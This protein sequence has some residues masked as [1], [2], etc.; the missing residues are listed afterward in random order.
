[1]GLMI[2]K[3]ADRVKTFCDDREFIFQKYGKG[4][5]GLASSGLFI[6]SQGFSR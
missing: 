2:L 4:R 6:L 5:K 3:N 1:M